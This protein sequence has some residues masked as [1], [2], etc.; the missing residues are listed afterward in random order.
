MIVKGQLP[1]AAKQSSLFIDGLGHPT[2]YLQHMTAYSKF[3]NLQSLQISGVL[4]I[5]VWFGALYG[6]N[7]QGAKSL[8]SSRAESIL[9]K[10]AW[11]TLV[12]EP[13]NGLGKA[14]QL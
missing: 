14:P 3:I 10:L 7:P 11:D 8:G 1:G 6:I 5:I 2:A 13:L 4:I 9:Q 12:K